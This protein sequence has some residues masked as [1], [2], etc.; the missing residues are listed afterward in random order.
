[1]DQVFPILSQLP[2]QLRTHLQ[3]MVDWLVNANLRG[4]LPRFRRNPHIYEVLDEEGKLRCLFKQFLHGDELSAMK[5]AFVYLLDHPESDHRSISP[6]IY[7]FS[8][9]SPTIF[10]RFTNGNETKMGVLV[11][12]VETVGTIGERGDIGITLEEMHKIVVA[13]IRFG[14]M[15]RHRDNILVRVDESGSAHLVPIDHEM[16]F[17]NEAQNYNL[18]GFYWIEWLMEKGNANAAFSQRCIDY[19]TRIKPDEDLNFLARCGWEANPNYAE[20]MKVFAIFLKKAISQGITAHDIGLIAAF[21]CDENLQSMVEGVEK[22]EN[23]L[24]NVSIRIENGLRGYY[25]RNM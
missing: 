14:N 6:D 13:D 20:Q 24:A 2:E 9:V 16:S 22:D 15:D 4:D 7:G 23:F 18:C 19:V 1:M 25:G 21:K 10:V 11:E 17:G 12:F 3:Q 8:S 5:E